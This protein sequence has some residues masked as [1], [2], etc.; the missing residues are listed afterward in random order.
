M[1][2]LGST[3]LDLGAQVR[4]V[5]TSQGQSPPV[6]LVGSEVQVLWSHFGFDESVSEILGTYLNLVGMGLML[7]WCQSVDFYFI[8]CV[9]QRVKVVCGVGKMKMG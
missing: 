8:V 2:G 1:S 4:K 9:K 3:P 5:D 7:V 6:D